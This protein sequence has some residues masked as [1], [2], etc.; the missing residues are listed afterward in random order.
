MLMFIKASLYTHHLFFAKSYTLF[1]R[2]HFSLRNKKDAAITSLFVTKVCQPCCRTQPI[3]SQGEFSY[4]LVCV[5]TM[6][7]LISISHMPKQVTWEAER[8]SFTIFQAQ[9]PFWRQSHKSAELES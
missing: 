9:I 5:L 8:S 2:P 6:R 7:F 1:E 3:Q 4:F